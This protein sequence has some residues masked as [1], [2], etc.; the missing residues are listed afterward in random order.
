M[1]RKLIL[2]TLILL[3]SLGGI[4]IGQPTGKILLEWWLNITGSAVTN[5]TGN[6]R[7]PIP[8]ISQRC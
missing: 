7:Y 2:I 4:A 1:C 3:L 8:H 5:L 6:A